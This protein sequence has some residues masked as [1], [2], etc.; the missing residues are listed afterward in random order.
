MLLAEKLVY[1][2]WSVALES[3][4]VLAFLHGNFDVAVILGVRIASDVLLE[5]VGAV[6]FPNI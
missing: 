2:L 1:I 6:V 5:D 3:G 4:S